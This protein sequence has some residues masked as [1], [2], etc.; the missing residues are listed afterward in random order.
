MSVIS[1]SCRNVSSKINHTCARRQI[2]GEQRMLCLMVA[3]NDGVGWYRKWNTTIIFI[4]GV[5]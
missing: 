4:K 3:V 5:D 2:S 1:I